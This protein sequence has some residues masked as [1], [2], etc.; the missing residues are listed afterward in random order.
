MKQKGA[1][2][3]SRFSHAPGPQLDDSE[4]H[5][6]ITMVDDEVDALLGDIGKS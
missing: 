2:K 3:K 5:P 4:G 1:K 6:M